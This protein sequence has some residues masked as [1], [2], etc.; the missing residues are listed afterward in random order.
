M[1]KTITNQISFNILCWKLKQIG[2]VLVY[3]C[4]SVQFKVYLL[5]MEPLYSVEMS[6]YVINICFIINFS[7]L[8]IVVIFH[9]PHFIFLS[10]QLLIYIY[11]LE[12]TYA[13]LS[14]LMLLRKAESSVFYCLYLN[15]SKAM[16]SLAHL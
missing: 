11:S 2:F 6:M 8:L 7:C 13:I 14:S 12:D 10:L 16:I 5:K 1:I 4:G 15:I 3:D 9:L